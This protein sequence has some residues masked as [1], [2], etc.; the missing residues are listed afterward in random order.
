MINSSSK[1][2]CLL[3]LVVIAYLGILIVSG[4]SDLSMHKSHFEQERTALIE[5]KWDYINSVIHENREGALRM[6]NQVK[7]EIIREAADEYGDDTE[8]L[9][10]DFKRMRNMEDTPIGKIIGDSTQNKWYKNIRNDNNDPFVM[11][12]VMILSDWS[13]NCSK[14]LGAVRTLADEIKGQFNTSLARSAITALLE[15][16]DAIIFWHYLVVPED[17]P[18]YDDIK[19]MEYM[20]INHVRNIF[21]KH[22]GNIHVLDGFEWLSAAY[23]MDNEDLQGNKVIDHRGIRHETDQ[24]IAVSGFNVVDVITNDPV[25]SVAIHSIDS[26]IAQAETSYLKERDARVSML[27]MEILAFFIAFISMAFLQNS[28]LVSNKDEK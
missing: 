19:D 13:N 24:L 18:W 17:A 4:Y 12:L 25:H 10:R 1:T 28:L 3:L 22:D 23:I 11:D 20:N 6:A 5:A 7:R 21:L 2:F 14:L 26:K 16:S 15:H 9:S 27:T 8:R